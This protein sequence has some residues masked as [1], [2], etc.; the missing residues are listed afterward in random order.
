MALTSASTAF[1]PRETDVLMQLDVVDNVYRYWAWQPSDPFPSEPVFE[2]SDDTWT[3]NEVLVGGVTANY[4]EIADFEAVFR[5]VQVADAPITDPRPLVG[6]L[7]E[8]GSLEV[9][10]VDLLSAAIRAG[11]MDPRF[12]VDQSGANDDRDLRYWVNELKRTWLGDANFDGVFDSRD[13]IEV[14]A[15]GEFEDAIALNSGWATG[16]WNGDG[17]FTTGDFVF[18]LADG[19][20][21]LGPRAGVNAVPEPRSQSMFVLA[22]AL[23]V[24]LRFVRAI[25]AG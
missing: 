8:D 25:A 11:S 5:F 7:N 20:F 10:D 3:D 16:D 24:K 6:D 12:D 1:H 21:E 17:D 14:L 2:L 18:A 9:D 22:L 4:P 19:G 23:M 13:L 15:A